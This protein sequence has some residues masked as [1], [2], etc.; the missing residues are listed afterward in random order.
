MSDINL[1]LPEVSPDT[2]ARTSAV[3]TP[4]TMQKI[5]LAVAL[6][7]SAISLGIAVFAALQRAGTVPEQIWSVAVSLGSVLCAHQ[8]PMLWRYASLSA[9]VALVALWLIALSVVLRGQ[10]DVLAFAHQHAADQRTQTVP[11]VAATSVVD[12]PPGRSLTTIAQDIATVSMDLAHV[13]AR[14]C[15]GDCRGLRARKDALSAQLVALNAEANEAKR[16][17]TEQD[18]LR[19]QSSRA[20]E[21]RE[22]RR[23]DPVTS[24][25]ANWLHTT[26]ARLNL[27]L[28]FAYVVVLEGT[29]CF[30][31]YFA[32]FGVVVRG[33]KA[34]A[35]DRNATM[36]QQETVAPISK[37]TPLGRA[38]QTATHAATIAEG[39]SVPNGASLGS[40]ISEDDLLVARIH[41]AIVAGRLTRNLTSIRNFLRCGQPKALR[42]NRLYVGR[43]GNARS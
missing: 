31:W 6:L 37:A 1:N 39:E 21:L 15:M 33:R 27:L 30:A 16:R 12:V 42:L 29:A 28:D 14:R 23:A 22:S 9:R 2:A 40:A 43:F 10:V 3:I 4:G 17:E 34:V 18:W 7:T 19:A 35:S 25:V 11:V 8:A 20:E 26:E 5:A 24:L 13:D 32:G 41:E 36:S 38:E